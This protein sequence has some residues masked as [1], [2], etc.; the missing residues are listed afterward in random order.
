MSTLE[1]SRDSRDGARIDLYLTILARIGSNVR[2]LEAEKSKSNGNRGQ[3]RSQ[4]MR[5]LLA[6][7][8]WRFKMRDQ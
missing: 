1:N 5:S 6:R 4:E 8:S 3:S 7:D 2:A